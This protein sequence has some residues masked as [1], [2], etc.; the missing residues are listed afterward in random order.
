MNKSEY[1]IN[2]AIE[3][4][5]R[6]LAELKGIKSQVDNCK[7]IASTKKAMEDEQQKKETSQT[8]KE[9]ILMMGSIRLDETEHMK[10]GTSTN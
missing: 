1:A 4:A 10:A 9:V 3:R 8:N 7:G 2:E 5:K 6:G